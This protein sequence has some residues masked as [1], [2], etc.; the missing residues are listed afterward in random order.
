MSDIIDK[1]V[2]ALSGR[3]TGTLP[4]SAKFVLTGAGALMIDGAGVRAGDEAADVTLSAAPEV[5][6]AILR[7]ETNPTV[8][9]MSGQL[10]VDGDMGMAMQLASLLS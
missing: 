10:T 3:L 4:G 6:E 9:F 5:F 8:A 7:G 2:A 1:A